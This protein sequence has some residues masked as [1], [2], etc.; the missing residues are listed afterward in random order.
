MGYTVVEKERL[1]K[2]PRRD[3]GGA[4][5]LLFSQRRL[6]STKVLEKHERYLD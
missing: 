1:Q 4:G 3:Q 2:G 5:Q 6:L